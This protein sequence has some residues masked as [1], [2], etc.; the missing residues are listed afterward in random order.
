MGAAGL[1]GARM[2][3]YGAPG[4]D[5]VPVSRSLTN[6]RVARLGFAGNLQAL[7]QL[8]GGSLRG[9]LRPQPQ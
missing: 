8:A 1:L 6:P 7:T 3:V 9:D 5:D 4:L 2:T